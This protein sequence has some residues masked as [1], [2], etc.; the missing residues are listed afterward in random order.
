MSISP[1]QVF[2][3][4]LFDGRN[5]SSIPKPK[6]DDNGKVITPDILKYNSPITHTF[7][8]SMFLRNG[9]LNYYLDKYFNDI[10]LRYLSREELMKFI[11]KCVIDFRINKRDIVFY[12]RRPRHVL[13]EKLREKMP[14]LKNDDISLLCDIVE[15]SD[16]KRAIF[17]SLGLDMPKKKT[18]KKSKKIKTKKISLKGFLDEYFSMISI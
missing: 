17:D 14:V 2:N 4:W 8:V 9:P 18:I 3:S 12:P 5:D 1:Y 16:N 6:I 13:Y 10:N 15:K 11:K 7:L